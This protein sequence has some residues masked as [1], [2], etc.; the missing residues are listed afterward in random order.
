MSGQ[1]QQRKLTTW[2]LVLT[3]TCLS[4]PDPPSSLIPVCRGA[5]HGRYWS[6]AQKATEAQGRGSHGEESVVWEGFLQEVPL[7]PNLEGQELA[8]GS[9]K[10]PQ[11]GSRREL[12]CSQAGVRSSRELERPKPA[13]GFSA[14]SP[15]DQTRFSLENGQTPRCAG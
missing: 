3:F 8:R 6:P 4:S 9:G 13:D 1:S 5:P 2:G 14:G 10:V 15:P 11:A 7:P 12:C